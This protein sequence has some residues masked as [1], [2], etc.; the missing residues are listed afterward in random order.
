MNTEE[1]QRALCRAETLAQQLEEEK[2]I[3]VSYDILSEF[4]HAHI[5]FVLVFCGKENAGDR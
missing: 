3:K 2:K 1:L 5:G 4:L